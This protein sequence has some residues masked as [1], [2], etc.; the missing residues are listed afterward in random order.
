[1]IELKSDWKSSGRRRGGDRSWR[2]GGS[3]LS[4]PSS[5]HRSRVPGGP[6]G[7][8]GYRAPAVGRRNLAEPLLSFVSVLQ[9]VVKGPRGRL[10]TLAHPQLLP[11]PAPAPAPAPE[12]NETESSESGPEGEGKVSGPREQRRT[13]PGWEPVCLSEPLTF[14]PDADPSG[15]WRTRPFRRDRLDS[16]DPPRAPPPAPPRARSGTRGAGP[17]RGAR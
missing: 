8:A 9:D 16:L 17:A 5:P 10:R 1:M 12:R 11:W 15:G 3:T 6:A 2:Y 7:E 4:R 13:W 14:P